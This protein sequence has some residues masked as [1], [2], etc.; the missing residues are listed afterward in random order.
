MGG[1]ATLHTGVRTIVSQYNES[2]WVSDLP[3]L[4]QG[5][6]GHGCSYYDNDD[7]TKVRIDKNYLLSSYDNISDIV[8]HRWL[9]S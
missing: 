4:L 1:R 7:G 2:G 3:D 6:S 9:Q 5:R 8:G